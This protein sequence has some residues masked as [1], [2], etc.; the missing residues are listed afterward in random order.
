MDQERERLLQLLAAREARRSRARRVWRDW[1]PALVV[2]LL[3]GGI[4]GAYW[5]DHVQEQRESDERVCEMFSD[6]AGVDDDD[7]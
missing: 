6:M 5:W 3:L 7:C 2:V 1:W 4:G